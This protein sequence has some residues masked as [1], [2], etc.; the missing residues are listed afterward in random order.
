MTDFLLRNAAERNGTGTFELLPRDIQLNLVN[1]LSLWELARLATFSR[2][3]RELFR[4]FLTPD[5]ARLLEVLGRGVPG[6][7]TGPQ[8][9]FLLRLIKD[10]VR[11]LLFA[12][13]WEKTDPLNPE[14]QS[15]LIDAEGQRLPFLSGSGH[16]EVC[17][18]WIEELTSS[19]L[20]SIVF[21]DLHMQTLP[22]CSVR[23]PGGACIEI[24]GRRPGAEGCASDRVP[25]DQ[26]ELSVTLQ[27]YEG[28][29]G[30]WFRALLL[31]V[32]LL[33]LN[34]RF[35]KWE[36]T[37]GLRREG[38]CTGTGQPAMSLQG[39]QLCVRRG[40]AVRRCRGT[41][42]RVLPDSARVPDG[43]NFVW[44]IEKPPRVVAVRL[45]TG[46]GQG[47][48]E[49]Q[50]LE[51]MQVFKTDARACIY[52]HVGPDGLSQCSFKTHDDWR[53]AESHSN[54]SAATQ[55]RLIED[56]ITQP[57][58]GAVLLVRVVS[59]IRGGIEEEGVIAGGTG[60]LS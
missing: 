31:G 18:R 53:T 59:S 40:T 24:S 48:K 21:P 28:D 51:D 60:P 41:A 16:V 58:P 11:G 55:R 25:S 4:S 35:S 38:S 42:V 43:G 54:D 2:G 9:G 20:Q 15:F 12:A 32:S 26:A 19:R 3:W 44:Y 57:N 17:L 47:W 22:R 52:Y 33:V 36:L 6:R 49:Y 8:L 1:P 56:I 45:L 34:R 50:V 13:H 14:P 30:E 5:Q 46:D 39:P 27:H 10:A 37:W 7:I 29:D 23:T